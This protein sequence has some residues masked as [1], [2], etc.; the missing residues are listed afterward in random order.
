M[1]RIACVLT[2]AAAL[3]AG[4]AARASDPIGGYLIVD[5]VVLDSA[6]APTTIQ[7]WGSIALATEERG[8]AYAT[9]VRGYLYYKAASGKEAVCRKEWSDLKKAAGTAQVIGFASSS[10]PAALG[11]VRKANEKPRE[12][13][14]YPLG[15]GLVKVDE[16]SER[17]HNWTPI[18]NLLALPAPKVPGEGSLVPRGEITL[19]TRNIPD[20]KRTGVKYVF[21][22]ES[23]SGDKEKGTVEA[24][25][26]E[27]KWTPK[28][29]LKAGEKYTW[30]VQA[31]QDSWKGP[32]VTSSFVVKRGKPSK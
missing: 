16:A 6:K 8:Q 25:K 3:A 12:P 15:T 9:P 18:R 29:K 13:D 30:R 2:L 1:F 4:G 17:S 22:L 19:V 26:K 14:V 10:D 20:K 7:I 24:G 5:K 23:D 28:L 32:V 27:T 21:E 11:K 31:T